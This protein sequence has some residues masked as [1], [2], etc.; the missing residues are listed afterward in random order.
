MDKFKAKKYFLHLLIAWTSLIAGCSSSPTATIV[1]P[2]LTAHVTPS[3]TEALST[4]TPTPDLYATAYWVTSTAI[5]EAVVAAE[6]PRI[7][8][9]YSS[10]DDKWRA[11]VVIYDCIQV[12]GPDVDSN[13]YEQLKLIQVSTGDQKI[14]DSQ[15]QNCG[16]LGA[17]GLEGLFWSSNS[18]YF[19]YSDAREGVPDGCGF[20]ERPVLRLEINTLDTEHLGGGPV[21]PD[22]TKIAAWKE[23][24]LVIWDLNEGIVKGQI[25]PHILNSGTGTGHIAWSP[26]SQA[27]VYI[28]SESYCPVSG[29]SIVV[30]VDL[31]ELEQ[32]ILLE[33]E[34]PTFGSANWLILNE[35]RLSD[36]NGKEWIYDFDTQELEPVS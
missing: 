28:Q 1:L 19:Y 11:E 26:D 5:V 31:P 4:P 13:A 8:G 10:P 36:E 25:S 20:W 23:D 22:G 16:G 7:H 33:S 18:Q 15:L 17:A 3:L 24:Q 6:E 14:V 27:L 34:S 2:T 9:S 30:R 32:T 35:L 21:S 29:N 12:A